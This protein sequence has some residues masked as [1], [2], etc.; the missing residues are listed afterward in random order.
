MGYEHQPGNG[1]LTAGPTT[2]R[3]AH[4]PTPTER[5]NPSQVGTFRTVD[6]APE[7]RTND[8]LGV[9]D[10]R[11]PANSDPVVAHHD[12]GAFG[13][14][15]CEIVEV[16]QDQFGML[17]SGQRGPRAKQDHR[18]V[19]ALR[20]REQRP[21]VGVTGNDDPILTLGKQEQ[22]DVLGSLEAEFMGVH[23]V[24]PVIAEQRC[25]TR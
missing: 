15:R 18:R 10:E 14:V 2:D 21:E 16:A 12:N 22:L 5:L 17:I 13:Q 4:N 9:V 7:S 8:H 25:Q 6:P 20:H 3:L 1:D 24:M 23:S 19:R 11:K